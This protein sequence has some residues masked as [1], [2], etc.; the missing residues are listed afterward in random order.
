MQSCAWT[1]KRACHHHLSSLRYPKVETFFFITPWYN[2]R[3]LNKT[4][5]KESLILQLARLKVFAVPGS[6]GSSKAPGVR[7]KLAII[8]QFL[9]SLMDGLPMLTF[10]FFWQLP[11]VINI[12][13][14]WPSKHTDTQTQKH[15]QTHFNQN[16]YFTKLIMSLFCIYKL[17]CSN[18]FYFIKNILVENLLIWYYK[19][20]II[21]KLL[22]YYPDEKFYLSTIGLRWSPQGRTSGWHMDA[23]VKGMGQYLPKL[24]YKTINQSLR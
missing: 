18:V 8:S 9:S 1:K 3:D 21:W 14:S 11:I 16:K 15:T 24:R 12:F 23:E 4:L 13:R 22:L 10:K 7:I 19:P 5:L 20:L 17:M 6:Q 2:G